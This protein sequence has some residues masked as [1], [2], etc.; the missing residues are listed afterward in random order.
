MIHAL[1]AKN[2]IG[3]IDGS[4]EMPSETDQPVEFASWNQ[5]NSMILLWLTHS[6]ESDLA[7]GVIHAKT[8]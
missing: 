4:I 6:V 1:T 3:F 5:C 7:Q 2:K 8:A